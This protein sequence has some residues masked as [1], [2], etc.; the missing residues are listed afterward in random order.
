M[1]FVDV[2]TKRFSVRSYKNHPVESE[3]IESVL[4][5][6]RIAPSAVNYQPW[7]FIVVMEKEGRE[8]LNRI[9]PRLWFQSAPV[10]IIICADHSR[11]WKR[12][13]DGFDSACVDAAIAIDHMT[14]RATDLG[15]G[16]CWVCNFD[17]QL[18]LSLF[19]I[20]EHIEPIALLPLGYPD[21]TMGEKKRKDLS[22]IVYWEKFGR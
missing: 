14:L 17:I 4:N 22:E 5:A 18:C 2:M 6:G 16:T 10:V 19:E 20:P 8:K 12:R 9:Y 13:S 21:E 15:L 11:S 3:K 1:D 7:F